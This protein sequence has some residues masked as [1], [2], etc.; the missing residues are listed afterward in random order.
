MYR[1]GCLIV[2]AFGFTFCFAAYYPGLLSPDALSIYR[3]AT[4]FSFSDWHA[5]M[6]GLLWALLD[7]LTHG[8]QGMLALLL[9]LYWGALFVLTVAA[10]RINRLIAPAML[11]LGFMPFTI[12]FAGTLWVDVLLATSWLM[13]SALAFSAYIRGRPISMVRAAMSWLFF[14]VGAWSRPNTLF[15]AIPLGL[16]LF[17]PRGVSRAL[18]R[19]ALVAMVAAGIWCGNWVMSYLVLHAERTYPI[20][21]IVTFDLAGIS[22][23]SGINY[24]PSTWSADET[25]KITKSCYTPQSWNEYAY[26]DCRFVR[27]RL[28]NEGLWGSM[29]LWRAWIAAVSR[30]P[31]AYLQHRWAHFLYFMTTVEYVLHEG[32]DAGEIYRRVHENFGFEIL[33]EYILRATQLWMFRPIFW[34]ALACASFVMSRHLPERSHRFVTTLALSSLIYLAT[35]FFVGVASNF[36]YAYWAVLAT[37]AASVIL[38]CEWGVR[39]R[40]EWHQF[41]IVGEAP[42]LLQKSKIAR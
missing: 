8:P 17:R 6:M 26:G 40:R 4:S 29:A 24:L 31:T 3:Q 33:R 38:A 41:R 7:R 1:L 9:T 34:F 18:Q 11:V 37:G 28:R 5:P 14:L 2:C 19:T 39:L 20:H 13:C 23:F 16:Y 22:H 27:D 42:I 32:N 21:S 25:A 15:A 30:E 10:S 35:Y 36:R 12:N